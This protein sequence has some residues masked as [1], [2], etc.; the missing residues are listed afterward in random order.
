MQIE[1]FHIQHFCYGYEIQMVGLTS[2]FFHQKCLNYKTLYFYFLLNGKENCVYLAL[3]PA[4]NFYTSCKQSFR[5]CIGISLPVHQFV[6]ISC[7]LSS[8]VEGYHQRMCMNK[9]NPGPKRFAITVSEGQI[10]SL[11]EDQEHLH[12]NCIQKKGWI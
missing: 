1:T 4:V 11:I 10:M 12:V 9:V 2:G 3:Q 6:R 7:Q 5:G 8:S